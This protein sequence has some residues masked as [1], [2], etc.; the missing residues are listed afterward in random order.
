MSKVS[1][2]EHNT[3]D[4]MCP[5]QRQEKTVI[6][7]LERRAIGKFVPPWQAWYIVRPTL[8]KR[9]SDDNELKAFAQYRFEDREQ[10]ILGTFGLIQPISGAFRYE[11]ELIEQ[12]FGG[13]YQV[14]AVVL[15]LEAQLDEVETNVQVELNN[16]CTLHE[17]LR[18]VQKRGFDAH[19]VPEI[20][21]VSDQSWSSFGQ[22]AK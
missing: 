15:G 20:L 7:M 18:H 14:E 22:D 4:S 16:P 9:G 11:V 2:R 21:A 19:G 1:R 6:Y 10:Q 8:L 12:V 3:I 13:S 17:M 5:G